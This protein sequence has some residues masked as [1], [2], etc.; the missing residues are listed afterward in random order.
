M[1]KKS[2]ARAAARAVEPKARA[3]SHAR[4]SAQEW[5]E[6]LGE[7]RRSG[8]TVDAFCA[9]RR[10]A[11]STFWYWRR[12]IAAGLTLSAKADAATR[13]LTV[14]VSVP[15]STPNEPCEVLIGGIR[16]R[17]GEVGGQCLLEA[18]V[19]RIAGAA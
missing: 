9:E 5:A 19:A 15:V 3:G 12:R 16:V 17:F 7:Q 13:F 11:R 2:K 4:H 14:P 10:L 6:L 1:V 8:L 18:L